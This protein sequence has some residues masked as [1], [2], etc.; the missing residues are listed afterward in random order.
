M[1]QASHLPC[2]APGF[3]LRFRSIRCAGRGF[4]FAC[5]AQGHVALDEF[6][7]SIRRSYLYARTVVGR[8]LYSPVVVP[9]VPVTRNAAEMERSDVTAPP[10]ARS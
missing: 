5:D 4:A 1:I 10:E 8:E 6:S 3:E 9:V 2:P 7:E